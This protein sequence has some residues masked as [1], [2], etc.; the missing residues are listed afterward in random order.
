MYFFKISFKLCV[1]GYLCV[2]VDVCVCVWMCGPV[3]T[4]ARGIQSPWSWR[5]IQLGTVRCAWW[6]LNLGN[7]EELYYILL[8]TELPLQ[9]HMAGM[10]QSEEMYH[11]RM[12]W[13]VDSRYPPP[14]GCLC[15]SAKGIRQLLGCLVAFPG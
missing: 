2:R 7:L 15:S 9:P 13:N 10:F 1:C 5:D 14:S 6:D 8:S 11:G 3:P 12:N 4:Q